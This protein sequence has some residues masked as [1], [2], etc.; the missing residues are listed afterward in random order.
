MSH[1]SAL[2]LL[3]LADSIPPGPASWLL[4]DAIH[5]TIPRSRRGWRPP[6]KGA[7]R[8]CGGHHLRV[9]STG[10]DQ[11]IRWAKDTVIPSGP[12]TDAM[13]HICSY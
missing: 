3:D 11:S 4:A 6:G 1:Q 13:R 5:L 8:P 12:R 9:A 2:D 7:P 10:M